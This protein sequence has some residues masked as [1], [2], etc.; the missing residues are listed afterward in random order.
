MTASGGVIATGDVLR[1]V[2][3]ICGQVVPSR[4]LSI[5]LYYD[6]GVNAIIEISSRDINL[7]RNAN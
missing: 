2:D 6:K 5:N 3:S 4:A 7:A 1:G